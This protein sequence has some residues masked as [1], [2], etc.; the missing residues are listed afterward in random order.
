LRVGWKKVVAER[1]GH[2]GKLNGREPEGPPAVCI[3]CFSVQR[4]SSRSP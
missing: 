1:G 2:G 4:L 3:C